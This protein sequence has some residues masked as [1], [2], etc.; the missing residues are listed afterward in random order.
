M[1]GRAKKENDVEQ[2]EVL[3][4]VAGSP[5]WDEFLLAFKI[6]LRVYMREWYETAS[7]VEEIRKRKRNESE[8]FFKCHNHLQTVL[9]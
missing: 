2:M 3:R 5:D 7:E 4:K 1:V 9:I 6:P 8:T